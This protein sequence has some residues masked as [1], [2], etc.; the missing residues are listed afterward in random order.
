MAPGRQEDTHE[1]FY[2]LVN[3]VEAIQLLEAGGKDAYD[4]RWV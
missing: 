2:S 1:L 3:A 4:E